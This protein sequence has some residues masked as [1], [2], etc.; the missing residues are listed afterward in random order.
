MNAEMRAE[1][2]NWIENV[3]SMQDLQVALATR[4]SLLYQSVGNDIELQAEKRVI[5]AEIAKR[6]GK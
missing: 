2:L 6:N 4:Q 1:W 5:L 3:A